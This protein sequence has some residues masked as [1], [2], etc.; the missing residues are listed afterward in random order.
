M[1]VQTLCE[2][3]LL[4]MPIIIAITLYRSIR[5]NILHMHS[6]NLVLVYM[7]YIN[8]RWPS[9]LLFQLG[10]VFLLDYII[11]MCTI[12]F[13]M[14]SLEPYKCHTVWCDRYIP[15]LATRH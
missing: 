11:I 13:H 15:I 1:H 3:L 6:T 2:Y 8:D 7:H 9:S 5:S 12:F 4:E 14:H 10:H